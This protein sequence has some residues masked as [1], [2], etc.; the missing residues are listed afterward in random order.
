LTSNPFLSEF[1][2]TITIF[3]FTRII[4]THW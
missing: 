4:K 2:F 1:L 3:W